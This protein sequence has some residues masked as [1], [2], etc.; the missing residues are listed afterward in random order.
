VPGFP[1]SSF[2]NSDDK[3]D[4]TAGAALAVGVALL[5][6]GTVLDKKKLAGAATPFVAV[7][8]IDLIVGA[9]VLGGNHSTLA[10]GLAAVG[11]GALV[12]LVGA[13]GEGRRGTTWIGVL[14]VFGGLVA[15][16]V[17]IDPDTAGGVGL[18]AVAFAL[19]L[20]AVALVL[21]PI[22][23]EDDED[24]DAPRPMP[25]PPSEPA[26]AATPASP[27]TWSPT[28]PPSAPPAPPVPPASG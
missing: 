26:A 17:D 16:L 3:T 11:S 21:G 27:L 24:D 12:G 20:I 14:T 1:S 22:L 5:A 28:S 6:V 23:G 15:V 8:A 2:D 7:G 18:I 4:E 10:G 9:I 19:G 25:A 13:R